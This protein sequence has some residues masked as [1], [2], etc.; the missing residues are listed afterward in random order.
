MNKRSLRVFKIETL[1]KIVY[2][3]GEFNHIIYWREK[4]VPTTKSL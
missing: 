2:T 3:K 4:D 1:V